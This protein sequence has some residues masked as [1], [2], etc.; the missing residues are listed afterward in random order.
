MSALKKIRAYYQI[1]TPVSYDMPFGMPPRQG[2][3]D[4]PCTITEG[5]WWV[6]DDEEGHVVPI[7]ET[8]LRPISFIP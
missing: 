5:M 6:R 8:R 7:P 4:G 3:I 1:G 2:T